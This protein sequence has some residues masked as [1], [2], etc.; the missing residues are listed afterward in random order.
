MSRLLL[1]TLVAASILATGTPLSAQQP[2][3]E[4]R[5]P[6]S[7][8]YASVA[9]LFGCLRGKGTMASAHRGG[10][11]P[12]Y[13]ENAMETVAHTLAA[14]PVLFESDIRRSRDGVLLLMHDETL[15]RT[16][17]GTGPVSDHDW[18][19]LQTLFLVDNDGNATD[20]RIPRFGDAIAW[21]KGRALMLAEVK[22][23]SALPQVVREI[24]QAEA[25]P[26][27]MLLVNSLEDAARVHELDP[28]ITMTL[29]VEELEA[30]DAYAEAG[31]DL[32][33]VIAWNGI[34]K[35]DRETWHAI[36]DRGLTL[37]YGTL[38]YIDTT[39]INLELEGIYAELAED[40]VDLMATDRPI[41][42]TEEIASVRP[43]VPAL[44][45]CNAV[46]S[47]AAR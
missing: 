27:V 5:V 44:R 41:E 30:L 46:P 21:T 47:G 34:G 16:T 1:N 38:W 3:P 20:F 35:R 24:Q 18:S 26:H 36:H 33:R 8:P 29:A 22:D 39:I 23:S 32:T 42:A 9:D 28:A 7:N 14:Q 11:A 12:G 45:Q 31:I 17:T 43:I 10:P 37:A 25:Q 40:G 6:V 2:L 13:P 15:D 4:P 19:S